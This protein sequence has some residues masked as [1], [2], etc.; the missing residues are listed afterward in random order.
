MYEWQKEKLFL[1]EITHLC[2]A[3]ICQW[4]QILFHSTT[5]HKR[6]KSFKAQHLVKLWKKLIPQTLLLT[7]LDLLQ[8][9]CHRNPLLWYYW[10]TL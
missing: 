5:A 4:K 8:L 6:Y 10:L 7:A 1:G 2:C 9:Q 3:R